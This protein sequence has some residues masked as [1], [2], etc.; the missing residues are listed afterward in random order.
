M[1]CPQCGHSNP[2]HA[3]FCVSC[4][5]SL[6]ELRRLGQSSSG[7]KSASDAAGLVAPG[8]AGG[9]AEAAPFRPFGKLSFADL[10]AVVAIG[11]PA[12]GL[13]S[14]FTRD[15]QLYIVLAILSFCLAA[16][17]ARYLVF[18]LRKGVSTLA[19]TN[20]Q[21]KFLFSFLVGMI[22]VLGVTSSIVFQ[23]K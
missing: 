2:Q 8:H 12:I 16:L 14:I 3:N 11:R 1:F 9:L 23:A 17:L 7:L 20:L 13:P 22:L 4:G 5:T 15:P 10:V 18:V 19:I 21:K 6:A